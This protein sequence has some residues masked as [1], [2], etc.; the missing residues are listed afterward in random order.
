MVKY[1]APRW[2]PIVP[3]ENKQDLSDTS[4]TLPWSA[5]SSVSLF[6]VDVYRL[7]VSRIGRFGP[8]KGYLQKGL[9]SSSQRN[10]SKSQIW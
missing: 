3:V 9:R 8:G 2:A 10:L 6:P 4:I 5:I 1:R 7:W